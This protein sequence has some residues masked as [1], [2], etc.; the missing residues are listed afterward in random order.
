MEIEEVRSF[1][2]LDI[3]WVIANDINHQLSA[4]TKF[5]VVMGTNDRIIPVFYI[6]YSKEDIFK[7]TSQQTCNTLSLP[8]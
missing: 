8:F 3:W 2:Y 1:L 6:L 5:P 4:A 7:L